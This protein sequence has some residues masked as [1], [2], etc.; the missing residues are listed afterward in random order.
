MYGRVD[1]PAHPVGELVRDLTGLGQRH[2]AREGD[3]QPVPDQHRFH[4]LA[5][6]GPAHELDL[7]AARTDLRTAFR[8][9]PCPLRSPCDTYTGRERQRSTATRYEISTFPAPRSTGRTNARC[10]REFPLDRARRRGLVSPLPVRRCVGPSGSGAG[11]CEAEVGKGVQQPDVHRFRAKHDDRQCVSGAP[12]RAARDHSVGLGTAPRS[13]ELHTQRRLLGAFSRLRVSVPPVASTVRRRWTR[14]ST[15]STRVNATRSPRPRTRSR[16]SPRPVRARRASSRAASRSARGRVRSKRV[17]CSRSRSPARPRAS[18]S[19]G[20]ARSASTGVTAGTFHALA[21]AQLRRRALE[22][23]R[24]VPTVL[25]SKARILGSLARDRGAAPVNAATLSDL[26]AEIEWAKARLV[27]PEQYATA[28][29]AAGRRPPRPFA[30]V[31]DIYAA[32]RRREAHQAHLRLRRP[33]LVVRG[34]DRGGSDVRGHPALAVPSRVRG[35]V[36]GR[37]AAAA[38]A[39]P[40]LARRRTRPVCRRRR[41]AGDLRLRGRG[42]DAVAG[43]RRPLSRR[44]PSS[45]SI[46]T[47]GRRRRSSP[48]PSR[49]SRPTPRAT[50][51]EIV[52]V[53]PGGARPDHARVRRRRGRSDRGRAGMLGSVHVRRAVVRDRC[54]LPHERAVVAVRSRAHAPRHPVPGPRRRSLRRATCRPHAARRAAQSRT[55]NTRARVRGAPGRPRRGPTRATT[56]RHRDRRARTTSCVSTGTRSCASVATISRPKAARATSPASSRGSTSRPAAS[57]AAGRPSTC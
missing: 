20:W 15:G 32:L 42:R 5:P 10:T 16:S 38:P 37:D 22:Q 3:A 55:G 17:T 48:S 9:P 34:R 28:A 29:R 25:A 2:P 51:P 12:A 52:A 1:A 6:A 47:T 44:Q 19:T 35:R 13:S 31:A 40:G 27:R 49:S 39:A 30:D 57:S 50:R 54:A 4:V 7:H 8:R 46:A 14:C 53:R 43:V 21:L 23:H 26:A 24:P 36:P 33:A 11:N 41:G 18:S 45:R 56:R